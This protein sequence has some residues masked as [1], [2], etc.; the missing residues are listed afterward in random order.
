MNATDKLQVHSPWTKRDSA[1]FNDQVITVKSQ[2]VLIQQ[3]CQPLQ[4]L[5]SF[6]LRVILWFHPSFI[7]IGFSVTVFEGSVP[8]PQY[9]FRTD[10]IVKTLFMTMRIV[11]SSAS[12]ALALI[13]MYF[14]EECYLA[15]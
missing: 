1:S 11:S 9:N 14:R 12:F 7:L 4:N 3:A 15:S 8:N 10:L 5:T 6:F 2:I 13:C